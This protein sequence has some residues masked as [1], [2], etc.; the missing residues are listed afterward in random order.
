MNLALL[1]LAFAVVFVAELADKTALAS[2]L[3]GVRYRAGA[4]FCGVAVAFSLHVLIAVAAGSALSLAPR[5]L[6][7]AV[8]AVLFLA[9]A[10]LLLRRARREGVLAQTPARVAEPATSTQ[11]SAPSPANPAPEVGVRL[12]ARVRLGGV[13]AGGFWKVAATSFAA[14]FVAEF[15][16]LTQI[17]TANLAAKYQDPLT[18]GIG[19]LLG[20]W[21]VAALAIL[22]GRQLLRWVPLR[23]LT[24]AAALVMAVLGVLSGVQAI[25]G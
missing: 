8:G 5:R 15:G 20:L 19:A 6:I 11:P 23:W 17:A 1:G 4:V 13:A 18:V 2:L 25:T 14:L 7:E 10:A 3:L 21:M 12:L 9:G 24:H 16:D 22:G